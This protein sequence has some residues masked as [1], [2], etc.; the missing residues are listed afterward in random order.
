MLICCAALGS[1]RPAAAQGRPLTKPRAAALAFKAVQAFLPGI[2]VQNEA[3]SY[4][5]G[6][7]REWPFAF[8]AS[9]RHLIGVE[10]TYLPARRLGHLVHLG[11]KFD[12]PLSFDTTAVIFDG[13]IGVQ[14]GLTMFT[15]FGDYGFAPEVS[16][17]YSLFKRGPRA[18]ARYRFNVWVSQPALGFQ[19]LSAGLS[20]PL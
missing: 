13:G 15:D 14:P 8:G 20:L 3:G 17:F 18:Y 10:Y 11:Y 9:G 4:L 6:M 7:T 2:V 5:V 1:P 16:I 12:I 19:D